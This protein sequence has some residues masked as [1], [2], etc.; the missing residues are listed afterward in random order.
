MTVMGTG[1]KSV[2]LVVIERRTGGDQIVQQCGSHSN[3]AS[4]SPVLNVANAAHDNDTLPSYGAALVLRFQNMC[5]ISRL[6]CCV[7][8]YYVYNWILA[9]I[10]SALT[11]DSNK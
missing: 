3:T 8:L 5:A 4:S 10:V 7:T 11:D 9:T 6:G 2:K 1:I